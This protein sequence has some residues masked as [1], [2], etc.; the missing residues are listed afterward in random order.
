[1]RSLDILLEDLAVLSKPASGL[2]H[3]WCVRS[4]DVPESGGM[5]CL[6]QVGEFVHDDVIDH[7]H[8]CFNQSPVQVHVVLWRA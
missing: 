2:F 7:E 4:D 5:I 8:R 1:M 6:N 3:C